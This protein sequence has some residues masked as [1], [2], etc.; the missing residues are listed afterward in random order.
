MVESERDAIEIEALQII[1]EDFDLT[2]PEEAPEVS[3]IEM[4]GSEE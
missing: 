4:D 3:D 2:L 1:D